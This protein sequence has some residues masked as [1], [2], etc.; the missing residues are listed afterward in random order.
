M[1]HLYI[2]GNFHKAYKTYAAAQA[3]FA[4]MYHI[5]GKAQWEIKEVV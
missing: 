3:A 4:N 2:N 5:R 1:F